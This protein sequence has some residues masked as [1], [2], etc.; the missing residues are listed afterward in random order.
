VSGQF[1]FACGDDLAGENSSKQAP[2]KRFATFG[3]GSYSQA[4]WIE[5]DMTSRASNCRERA[6]Q[7]ERAA[8]RVVDEEIRQVYLDLAEQWR[9][10]ADHSEEIEQRLHPPGP[11]QN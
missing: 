2:V 11:P 7:C 9:R 4:M 1:V 6:E 3:R 10:M 5:C 8:S